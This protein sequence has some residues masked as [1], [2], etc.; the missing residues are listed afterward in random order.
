[1]SI[2]SS[3]VETETHENWL[4]DFQNYK[5]EQTHTHGHGSVSLT[6]QSI[7]YIPPFFFYN[8]Q[9]TPAINLYDIL[10]YRVL[11]LIFSAI[12]QHKENRTNERKILIFIHNKSI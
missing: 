8:V 10:L 5:W 4:I 12:I 9:V 2:H 11:V 6:T 3:D 1:M 7:P